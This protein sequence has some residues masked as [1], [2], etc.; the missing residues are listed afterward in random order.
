MS[1]IGTVALDL[2]ELL[3]DMGIDHEVHELT[4]DERQAVKSKLE[5]TIKTNSCEY[6][7]PHRAMLGLL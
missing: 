2:Q 4:T 1:K 3:S 7:C 6:S 5:E